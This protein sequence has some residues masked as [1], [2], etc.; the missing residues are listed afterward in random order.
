M[1]TLWFS[2]FI[3]VLEEPWFYFS[4]HIYHMAFV[5][6]QALGIYSWIFVVAILNVSAKTYLELY[7]KC[8]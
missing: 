5:H 3:E 7:Q 4:L 6:A 2:V 8:I 1:Q